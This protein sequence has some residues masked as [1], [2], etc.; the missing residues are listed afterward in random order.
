MRCFLFQFACS[1]GNRI[2]SPAASPKHVSS[3]G[4]FFVREKETTVYRPQAGHQLLAFTWPFELFFWMP[5]SFRNGSSGQSCDERIRVLGVRT[6]SVS[7]RMK[8]SSRQAKGLSHVVMS[9]ERRLW[10]G[11]QLLS[12]CVLPHLT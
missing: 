9:A 12:R 7:N 4:V 8:R 2:L 11:M 3:C 5:F 1:S 10:E 6:R